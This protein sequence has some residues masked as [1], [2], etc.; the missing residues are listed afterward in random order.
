M[1]D[2]ASDCF[3]VTKLF[4]QFRGRDDVMLI[5]HIGGR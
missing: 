5:P 3:L 1:K 4:D 2:A